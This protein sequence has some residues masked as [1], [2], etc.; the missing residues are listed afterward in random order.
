VTLQIQNWN[1]IAARAENGVIGINNR[2]PWSIPADMKWFGEATN[3]QILV[4]GRK[5]L[6]SL[7]ARRPQNTYLVLTRDKDYSSPASNVELIHGLDQ[8]PADD[9]LGRSIWICGGSSLYQEALSRCA[10]LYLTTIKAHYEGDA[11]FPPFEDQFL[12]EET[13][14]ED[15]QMMI[16]RYRNKLL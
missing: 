8:I 7:R 10:Y 15:E 4:L 2:L 16:Q 9:P 14:Q 5:T 3:G 13:L 11:Y 1:A 12:L 6:E